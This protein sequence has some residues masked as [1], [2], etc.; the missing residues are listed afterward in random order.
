MDLT[1]LSRAR[2]SRLR[3]TLTCRVFSPLGKGS[4]AKGIAW[5][6]V[7]AVA[8]AVV[9]DDGGALVLGPIGVCGDGDGLS[10][11]G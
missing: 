7:F 3:R 11:G 10:G 9:S 2:K 1:A 8:V 5:T 4:A 6:V